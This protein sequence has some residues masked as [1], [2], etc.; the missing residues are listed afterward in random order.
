MAARLLTCRIKSGS[1]GLLRAIGII[2]KWVISLTELLVLKIDRLELCIYYK[3]NIVADM[4]T[5]D[6]YLLD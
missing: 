5:K 1:A 4:T 6:L 2:Y 3:N